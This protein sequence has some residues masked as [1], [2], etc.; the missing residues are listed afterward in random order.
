M[1]R[2]LEKLGLLE[3][4]AEG[5]WVVSAGASQE[6]FL[7]YWPHQVCTDRGS[8]GVARERTEAAALGRLSGARPP[9]I[10][11]VQLCRPWHG[12][13]RVLRMKGRG[14]QPRQRRAG[15]SEGGPDRAPHRTRV[16]TGDGKV[17]EVDILILATGFDAGTGALTRIDIRGRDGRTL[18]DEWSQEI[19]TTMGLAETPLCR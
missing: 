18:K 11:T 13:R 3:V 2:E 8:Q 15:R 17:H 19:H 10:V 14:V 9:F 4:S 7:P 1:L 5:M 12:Q 6:W 16:L